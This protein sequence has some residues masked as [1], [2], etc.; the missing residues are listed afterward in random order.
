MKRE[1]L[2]SRARVVC[3]RGA[4]L[5]EVCLVCVARRRRCMFGYKKHEVGVREIPRRVSLV[6]LSPASH[7]F[8][9][10]AVFSGIMFS[11][12]PAIRH[13]F[14][15]IAYSYSVLFTDSSTTFTQLIP[16]LLPLPFILPIYDCINQMFCL[17]KGSFGVLYLSFP[18]IKKY[19]QRRRTRIE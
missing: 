14:F 6:Q 10:L 5:R 19:L 17:I 9:K 8:S 11:A 13:F 18:F 7:L 4:V 3:G 2:R 15:L 12:T 16:S 1:E